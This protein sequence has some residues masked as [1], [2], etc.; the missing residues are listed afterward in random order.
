MAAEE[1]DE[2]GGGVGDRSRIGA[3][4][5]GNVVQL[6]GEVLEACS[7]SSSRRET[8]LRRGGAA[9]SP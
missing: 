8:V 3:R 2:V 6:D 7:L 9:I 1:V 4:G 5:V